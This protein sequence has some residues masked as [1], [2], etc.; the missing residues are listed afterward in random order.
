MRQP[1][2]ANDGGGNGSL[3]M[4]AEHDRDGFEEL[5]KRP[6]SKAKKVFFWTI[7]IF[8][9]VLITPFV[10]V[11]LFGPSVAASAVPGI[12][13]SASEDIDGTLEV[14]TVKLSWF[15]GAEL[16]G[17]RLLDTDGSVIG[18]FD[19]HTNRGILSFLKD[20]NDLGELRLSGE[21][22]LIREQ[23]GRFNLERVLNIPANGSGFS[24]GPVKP[25]YSYEPPNGG[26]ADIRIG[27]AEFDIPVDVRLLAKDII[28]RIKDPEL[29]EATGGRFDA[30]AFEGVTID[31]EASRD[32]SGKAELLFPYALT[33]TENASGQIELSSRTD[34]NG[35]IT[36]NAVLEGD[37]LSGSF[38]VIVDQDR[39]WLSEPGA[40][41]VSP[42]LTGWLSE[43]DD[44]LRF[45]SAPMIEA[46]IPT[47]SVPHDEPHLAAMDASIRIGPST[48]MLTIE[49]NGQPDTPFDVSLVTMHL[50]VDPERGTLRLTGDGS[51]RVD[52]RSAGAFTAD[53]TVAE[54]VDPSGLLVP[55]SVEG[56]ISIDGVAS[57]LLQAF[58]SEDAPDLEALVGPEFAIGIETETERDSG[59]I[60]ADIAIRSLHARANAPLRLTETA[61]NA[62]GDIEIEHENLGAA[63][64]LLLEPDLLETLDLEPIGKGSVTVKDFAVGMKLEPRRADL[65]SMEADIN[66]EARELSISPTELGPTQVPELSL[67]LM[68]RPDERIAVR[69]GG[70]ARLPNA[71]VTLVADVELASLGQLLEDDDL[72]PSGQIEISGLPSRLAGLAEA[73]LGELVPNLVGTELGL[74]LAMEDR[75]AGQT[76]IEANVESPGL[77]ARAWASVRGRPTA[78][79]AVE[80]DGATATLALTDPSVEALT[81]GTGIEA[82][83]ERPATVDIT[84]EPMT[85]ALDGTEVANFNARLESD[86]ALSS[87]SLPNDKG[88]REMGSVSLTSS[89]TVNANT[90]GPIDA[91]LTAEID[92]GGATGT[93]IGELTRSG[94]RDDRIDARLELRDLPTEPAA[95]L[96]GIM[97]AALLS[98]LL[99][100]S[101]SLQI[102]TSFDPIQGLPEGGRLSIDSPN[103][104]TRSPVEVTVTNGI[105][106]LAEPAVIEGTIT[107]SLLD[108]LGSG[109]NPDAT[110]LA[111][112]AEY[113]L[114]IDMLSIAVDGREPFAP[115]TGPL[116]ISLSSPGIGVLS[117]YGAEAGLDRFDLEFERLAASPTDAAISLKAIGREGGEEAPITFEGA[118]GDLFGQAGDLRPRL[119]VIDGALRAPA[120]PVAVLD[121]F[122]GADGRIAEL[123]GPNAELVGQFDALS[124][125]RGSLEIEL[126]SPRTSVRIA[127]SVRDGLLELTGDSGMDQRI[128][129]AAMGRMITRDF[130]ALPTIEKTAAHQPATVQPA[131][132]RV[133]LDG[134][135]A[136]LNGTLRIDPGVALLTR[137]DRLASVLNLPQTTNVGERL[138]PVD[139]LFNNGVMHIPRYTIPLGEFDIVI[140]GTHDLVTSELDLT[141]WA[142][143]GSLTDEAAGELNLGLGGAFAKIAGA[144]I[145]EATMVP[146]RFKGPSSSPSI[147]V[148]VGE[149]VESLPGRIIDD[150]IIE[151]GIDGLLNGI[152]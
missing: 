119:A 71:V 67:D 133:P 31:L 96:A 108:A 146:I 105:A 130:P 126:Q 121:A 139:L 1:S 76:D 24:N 10:L 45:E 57:P 85:I 83:L 124:A 152:R 65:A 114:G 116:R 94:E 117:R 88:R 62:T 128:V 150:S 63:L 90:A 70:E 137:S 138:E 5:A 30:F 123:L 106:Q 26:G 149:L 16:D 69:S 74:T 120:L 54:I 51:A 151:R 92:A 41:T 100:E 141:L 68:V 78:P 95:G 25:E 87:L 144:T 42:I 8:F 134:E 11:V 145:K 58:L 13:R 22:N 82:L 112:A 19:A 118:I 15:D 79:E 7:V 107:Q 60:F 103:L 53:F 109:D 50:V 89:M 113:N 12:I 37:L 143:L 72:R 49:E 55:K 135:P 125:T 84:I 93:L 77:S 32:G 131:S 147:K 132:L 98:A 3:T 4:A 9:T 40:L 47:L 17:L 43:L 129:T 81:R 28:V 97:D 48:G 56:G 136:R 39:L 142:P 104:R 122:M 75:G 86:L 127:G 36:S 18:R 64:A 102:E 66:V 111:A 73:S 61:I 14:D 20:P 80:I 110:R 38:R 23:D 52:G 35:V 21:L 6:P 101:A 115:G 33:G 59:D 99:G 2:A 148:D 46:S 140:E 44:R 91:R 29:L 34:S 27:D